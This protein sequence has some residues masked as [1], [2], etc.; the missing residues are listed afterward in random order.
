V[1]AV[2]G[3]PGFTIKLDRIEPPETKLKARRILESHGSAPDQYPDWD[4]SPDR[5]RADRPTEPGDRPKGD[6]PERVSSDRCGLAGR[7]KSGPVFRF[8]LKR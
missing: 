6:L 3:T 7:A 8:H 4:D 1:Y 2:P 5:S